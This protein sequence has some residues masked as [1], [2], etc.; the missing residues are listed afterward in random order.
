[1]PWCVL[2]WPEIL[3]LASFSALVCPFPDLGTLGSE[4]TGEN[5]WDVTIERGLLGFV[6]FVADDELHKVIPKRVEA[7]THIHAVIEVVDDK[8]GSFLPRVDILEPLETLLDLRRA[9]HLFVPCSLLD[10]ELQIE[11]GEIYTKETNEFKFKFKAAKNKKK[12]EILTKRQLID[13][14]FQILRSVLDQ[15]HCRGWARDDFKV[16][17]GLRQIL[18]EPT[19]DIGR[20]E[21][22][23]VSAS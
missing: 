1:M 13:P 19:L 16:T 5:G 14:V 9:Q 6:C 15:K 7:T 17:L 3:A 18:Q 11:E 12:R 10:P 20:G 8:G 22:Q 4:V 2:Q 23:R 21:D